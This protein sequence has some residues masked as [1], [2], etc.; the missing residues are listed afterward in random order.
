MTRD[1]SEL[2][3][4]VDRGVGMPGSLVV[5]PR[6]SAGGYPAAVRSRTSGNWER[7]GAARRH[8][9]R[10]LGLRW[11]LLVAL[12]VQAACSGSGPGAST[13]TPLLVNG[14]PALVQPHPRAVTVAIDSSRATSAVIST[15][16]GKL[17]ASAADGTTFE[18][19]L[20]A[21]SLTGEETVTMTP[22]SSVTG[23][24][25][26]VGHIEGVKL[27]PDGLILAKPAVLTIVPKPVMAATQQQ[28]GFGY[29]GQGSDF[30]FQ[31]LD[32][33]AG[34]SLHILHFSGCGVGGAS[35]IDMQNQSLTPPTQSYDQ[36]AQAIELQVQTALSQ[37]RTEALLGQQVDVSG[38]DN[39]ISSVQEQ[40]YDRVLAPLLIMAESDPAFANDAL[41]LS[42]QYIRTD[43]LLGTGSKHNQDVLNAWE[44]IWQKEISRI[45][46]DAMRGTAT[47]TQ[48]LGI[49][50][51]AQLLGTADPTEVTDAIRR[52]LVF[53]LDFDAEA[54]WNSDRGNYWATVIQMHGLR[55][56]PPQWTGQQQTQ[57]TVGAQPAGA[58]HQLHSVRA[59]DPFVVKAMQVDLRITERSNVVVPQLSISRLALLMHPGNW[60]ADETD[61]C[62]AGQIE[63]SG[64]PLIDCIAPGGSDYVPGT[65]GCWGSTNQ[66]RRTADGGFLFTE[67]T[68]PP[69]GPVI[70][71]LS[72]TGSTVV[73][74]IVLDSSHTVMKLTLTP[75][76]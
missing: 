71:Q 17:H 22:L 7:A 30:H 45:T 14:I 46:C 23:A 41:I 74:G 19:S 15:S 36:E 43:E 56:A 65:F 70:A 1:I 73:D 3:G 27:E 6:G 32:P 33:S 12:T 55:L 75:G 66:S 29:H 13:T 69:T 9:R 57:V 51:Q 34:I 37:A 31:M 24:P 18:L 10:A 76:G 11:F 44:K 48:Y 39:A 42:I 62:D 53:R 61:D 60:L 16:G 21:G 50:R 72:V 28:V 4:R 2:P 35:P 47:V 8:A 68:Y 20:P 49:S 25:L 58:C 63:D 59:G 5:D 38:V 40:Y 54:Q 26:S 67:W 64:V 52:C